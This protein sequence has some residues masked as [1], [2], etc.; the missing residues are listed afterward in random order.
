LISRY[1]IV[2]PIVTKLGDPEESTQVIDF[3]ND[4]LSSYISCMYINDD[5]CI[6]GQFLLL[7][8]FLSYKDN[9]VFELYVQELDVFGDTLNTTFLHGFL[10][11]GCPVHLRAIE[12]TH[13]CM[14]SYPFN[15]GLFEIILNRDI[16]HIS[17]GCGHH[18]L[19]ISHPVLDVTIFWI[20][21]SDE[22]D[23]LRFS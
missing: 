1:G 4:E 22:V 19:Y 8:E 7:R 3:L 12:Y 16:K 21:F 13:T 14:L 5:Q 2:L 9:G 6:Q 20:N 11:I 10:N 17:D 15:S 23:L 18:T